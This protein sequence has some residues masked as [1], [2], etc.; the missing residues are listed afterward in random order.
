[1][2]RNRSDDQ[3]KLLET[4]SPTYYCEF[5]GRN[6]PLVDGGFYIHDKVPHPEDYIYGGS[7]VNLQKP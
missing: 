5:C 2:N 6:L 7:N 4:L 3:T 1:M